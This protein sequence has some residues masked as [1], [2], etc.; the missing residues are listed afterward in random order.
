MGNAFKKLNPEWE[1]IRVVMA[2]KDMGERDVLKQCLPNANELICLFHT[3]R[4]FR[5]GVTCEKM[6]IT[7][8]QRTVCLDLIQKLC[9]AHSEEEYLD[10]YSPSKGLPRRRLF[11]T[12]MRFGTQNEMSGY[13]E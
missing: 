11:R 6:G 3:L 10:L 12:S 8:G 2:A 5:R 1:K 9:Y 4:S 13:S 7:S